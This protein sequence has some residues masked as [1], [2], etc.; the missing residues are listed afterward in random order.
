MY[1]PPF[2][3]SAK[4]INLI[5]EISAQIERYSI[6]M[7]TEESLLLRKANRVKTIHSSLAIEGNTLSSDEVSDIINGKNV[8]APVKQI[9]EVRNAIK[10]YELY[11]YLD[12][13]SM[14]DLLKAHGVMMEALTDDAGMFRKR[15]VGVYAGTN[16]VHIAPQAHM[17]PG[18]MN[19]LFSWLRS[20]EDHL[21]IKSCVFHYE[22]EFIHPFSD[23]NG[24]TGRLWQSLILGKL[25]P[26]FENLPVENMV[27]ANQSAY[28]DAISKSSSQADSGPFIEYMLEEILA[29]LKAHQGTPVQQRISE[30]EQLVLDCIMEK[31]DSS[32][33]AISFKTGISDRQ[34]ERLIASLKEKGILVRSGSR[35]TGRWIVNP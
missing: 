18:L 8:I 32:A 10:T 11:P 34:V 6:K 24:R 23:G 29:S 19:D 7:G 1:T 25:H 13:Y 20:S 26:L 30:K 12:P 2:T 21:L 33:K 17:V 15:G 35:K 27:Y 28:Y 3:V 31:P 22:F 5:A 14:D 16:A 9:Q 4:V